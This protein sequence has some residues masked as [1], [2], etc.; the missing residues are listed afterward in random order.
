MLLEFVI[1]WIVIIF[2]MLIFIYAISIEYKYNNI[3][4]YPI[5][6]CYN[7]YLCKQVVNVNGVQTVQEVNMSDLVIF[8]NSSAFDVCTP[9]T[10]ENICSFTY[11]N[12]D[13]Q[14]VTEQPA[15]YINTWSDEPTCSATDNYAGCP[16]YSVG[17]IYWRACYNGFEGNSFNNYNRTYFNSNIKISNCN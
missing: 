5:P 6:K 12:Q 9:L 17:D 14:V 13:G 10:N 8:G 1:M 2:T 11:T 4:T 15:T 16:Y 7:D 3:L